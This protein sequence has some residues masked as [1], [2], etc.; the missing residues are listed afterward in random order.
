[1]KNN[2]IGLRKTKQRELVLG[3]ISSAPGPVSVNEI[4]LLLEQCSHNIGIA[5][6]YRTVNLLMDNELIQCVRLQDA[7]QRYEPT[8]IPHHHHFHCKQCDKVYDLEGCYLH[9]DNPTLKE[10]HQASSHE[11]TFRGICKDCGEKA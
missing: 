11:I 5:T 3:V 10:G 4:V 2:Q 7:I 9:L 6:I 8:N 1:M